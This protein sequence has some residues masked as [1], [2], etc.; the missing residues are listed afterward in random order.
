[1]EKITLNGKRYIALGEFNHL[2]RNLVKDVYDRYE[3]DEDGKLHLSEYDQGQIDAL[4][5][6]M[7]EIMY[8]EIKDAE[9]PEEIKAM[10]YKIESEFARHSFMIVAKDEDTGDEVY[11]RKYCEHIEE[12]EETPVF[13]GMKRLAKTWSDHYA[14][15]ITAESLKRETGNKSIKVVP[16]WTRLL[17]AGAEKKLLNAIFGDDTDDEEPECKAK[18]DESKDYKDAWVIFTLDE[19]DEF[20]F[21]ECMQ[22][23]DEIP[24]FIKRHLKNLKKGE[25]EYAVVTTNDVGL[26]TLYSTEEQANEKIESIKKMCESDTVYHTTTRKM[27]D[28]EE[29][30]EA[31]RMIYSDNPT[32]EPEYH[33]DGTRAEN[34][35]WDVENDE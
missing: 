10:R 3:K 11:F 16:A 6:I 14:A 34:E 1:M 27:F 15:T 32:K 9:S 19:D 21:F 24:D 2:R 7:T 25:N 4:S 30:I 12:D 17:P 22:H 35:D 29:S 13:T 8:E 31:M 23:M 20:H 26:A 18:S 28:S 5:H 33:G